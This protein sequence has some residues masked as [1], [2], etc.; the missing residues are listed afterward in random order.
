MPAKTINIQ[1]LNEQT[2]DGLVDPTAI[3]T[4]A[5]G[6][7][8]QLGHTN[9]SLQ[10]HHAGQVAYWTY[11]DRFAHA[12]DITNES[13]DTSKVLNV[14]AG[15]N[16]GEGGAT[17][18]TAGSSFTE[19]K[20]V[21]LICEG[22]IEGFCDEYGQ[23]IRNLNESD[24]SV[25]K[26]LNEMYVDPRRA[27]KS[28]YLDDTPVVSENGQLNF[29]DFTVDF[30]PGLHN[31]SPMRGHRTQGRTKVLNK[32]LFP[33]TWGQGSKDSVGY[34]FGLD[35]MGTYVT[36]KDQFR[37]LEDNSSMIPHTITDPNVAEVIIGINIRALSRT[38][39]GKRTTSTL[40]S[41][42]HFLI[43]VGN[44]GE[45]YAAYSE[46]G[47]ITNP[48]L[49]STKNNED[50]YYNSNFGGYQLVRAKGF[51]TS[52]YIFQI[53]V[54]LPPNPNKKN[55]LIKVSR[56]DGVDAN[57]ND[58]SQGVAHSQ[59][60]SITE[61]LPYSFN[62]PH[63]A[64]IGANFDS[65][66]YPGIPNR[67]YL[68]KLQKVKVPSNYIPETKKYVGNWN[69]QFKTR[70]SQ[71]DL[72]NKKQSLSTRP[73]VY[74]RES[75]VI[76]NPSNK[77]T[78]ST[79]VG[80]FGEKGILNF[81]LAGAT[82]RPSNGA[83]HGSDKVLRVY[84][85]PESE[86]PGE[87]TFG[88]PNSTALPFKN[89]YVGDD[90]LQY[91][92]ISS[93]A[94]QN[95]TIEFM[96]K[97]D[98]A[99]LKVVKNVDGAT[100]YANGSSA[101]RKVIIASDDNSG[102]GAG[103]IM[104][105]ASN[106]QI[107]EAGKALQLYGEGNPHKDIGLQS[108]VDT[109]FVKMGVLN[110]GWRIEV[111]TDA[112]GDLGKV[113]FRAFTSNGI[114]S[115]IRATEKGENIAFQQDLKDV[116]H[117]LWVQ[118][119]LESD[120][121]DITTFS[122]E[123]GL[124]YLQNAYVDSQDSVLQDEKWHHIAVV[125]NGSKITMYFDGIAK[126]SQL[127]SPDMPGINGVRMYGGK[128]KSGDKTLAAAGR[129]EITIGGTR[130]PIV[131]HA[132][133]LHDS[134]FVGDLDNIRISLNAEYND[135]GMEYLFV[136]DGG[137][138]IAALSTQTSTKD[139]PQNNQ[140][141][142]FLIKMHNNAIADQ[143]KLIV[144]TSY[145]SD[146]IEDVNE[147]LP[148]WTD[149]P[150][151]IYYD[152]ATNSRYGLG[153]YGVDA[154]S[155]DKWSLYQI[156]KYCDELV[157]TGFSSK[158]PERTF[159]F[160]D[161]GS[162]LDFDRDQDNAISWRQAKAGTSM[163]KIEGFQNQAQFEREFPE[164]SIINI[165][166]LNDKKNV[167]YQRQI[168]YYRGT[169]NI[170][171]NRPYK[172]EYNDDGTQSSNQEHLISYLGNGINEPGSA[173]VSLIDVIP[174]EESLASDFNIKNIL[175]QGYFL[176]GSLGEYD[177][178]LGLDQEI[179]DREFISSYV[180]DGLGQFTNSHLTA[181]SPVNSTSLHGKVCAE[182]GVKYPFLEP[183][184]RA[185]VYIDGITDGLRVL[186]DIAAVFRG[187]TY[188]MG[189][190]IVPA[191]D[192]PKDP[193][194][195]FTN[196][197]VKDGDFKYS[198]T[199]KDQRYTV[200]KVRYNDEHD[201]YKQR[202]EFIEDA[203]GIIRY[204]YNE[205]D[206]AALGCTSRGQARRLG[207]WFLY[208]AQHET[209]NVV[210]S[211][212]KQAAYLRPGD[213]VK[214]LD[215]NRI[216][217]KNFGRVL[218]IEDLASRKIK[219]DSELDE[220]LIGETITLEIPQRFETVEGLNFRADHNFITN[221]KTLGIDTAKI[222]D[223]DVKNMRK[224]QLMTFVIKDIIKDTSKVPHVNTIIQIDEPEGESSFFG[225]INVGAPFS[226]SRLNETIKVKEDLFRVINVKQINLEEY[227]LDCLEFNE[228]KHD[229]VDFSTELSSSDQ[230]AAPPVTR[231]SKM[232]NPPKVNLINSN[233]QQRQLLI[234]WDPVTPRPYA[235]HVVLYLV[236]EEAFD[237][238][239]SGAAANGG[240]TS[241]RTSQRAVL[242]EDENGV[243]NPTTIIMNIGSF[244]GEIKVNIW[245]QDKDGRKEVV[246]F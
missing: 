239:T 231:P 9:D 183:R 82:P 139:F 232:I 226:V 196:S 162:P 117:A 217:Q 230:E 216:S 154:S 75:T 168:V 5:A 236:G 120:Q 35:K 145:L 58:K 106:D 203:H 77:T 81:P 27:S 54:I 201:F 228:T 159:S 157:K 6:R 46:D 187:I 161:D 213:V 167:A 208:T 41:Y 1:P 37:H 71:I 128:I 209:E 3:W 29:R 173:V 68:L 160:I 158:Y 121:R 14:K 146:Q 96:I 166:S 30:K 219:I 32:D 85:G 205:K 51:V 63:S 114:T 42:L 23:T 4:S 163:I 97:I 244:T 36:T 118:G 61:I 192:Q 169:S 93:F 220:R 49:W 147:I 119:Q 31:Q 72:F 152:I 45:E 242:A 103:S 184:F 113:Y 105:A 98:T 176:Q 237:G 175:R 87:S 150:A 111:G 214:I 185:N 199:P 62:H 11:N 233:P 181:K 24:A 108:D 10:D 66:A 224:P 59:L 190:K 207:K 76:V 135:A 193:I 130:T 17:K 186:N 132:G 94:D 52:D 189:G 179:T 22:P 126:H 122:Q 204:G 57:F 200:C 83:T 26:G 243:E 246:Y 148:Q 8:W 74:Q 197:N 178:H 225:K 104:S 210:F 129:G 234:S 78:V 134:T 15:L 215:K 240:E 48:P 143:N 112:S 191:F 137:G 88:S 245:T 133:T 100:S 21:D 16:R 164:G 142:R 188:Y 125:R 47:T 39:Q 13:Q 12:I 153:K 7:A 211:T 102:M 177:V 241:V 140:M 123:A 89:F 170:L 34:Y 194:M 2:S 116:H 149:N 64:L 67:K 107:I 227:E 115:H 92:P 19:A 238:D 141:T 73:F 70:S 109:R 65:R 223:E 222:S 198:G 40:M 50:Y 221:E 174:V 95:F 90:A 124:S 212:G 182:H 110:G 33:G 91:L 79:S 155:V 101:V 55:R 20:I 195:I 136:K 156:A 171:D 144:D 99:T 43:Y 202:I 206:L 138:N 127:V 25:D 131:A 38:K 151:W 86:Q 218:S 18:L 69:G 229:D 80:A 44:E 56:M 28:I 235:Y 60:R 172:V 180:V 84:D 53:K 165:Y